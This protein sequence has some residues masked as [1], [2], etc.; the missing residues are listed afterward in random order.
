MIEL[1][2]CH[3]NAK[4][5]YKTRRSGLNKIFAGLLVL[6]V[7]AAGPLFAANTSIFY[8]GKVISIDQP[9]VPINYIFGIKLYPENLTVRSDEPIKYF[10][11]TL[12][13]ESNTTNNVDI[14]I[15]YV[16]Q[17]KGW[18]AQLIEDENNDG[19]HQDSEDKMLSPKQILA[20]GAEL[21]F[22]LRLA[23]PVDSRSG[24]AG[25]AIIKAS[26]AVK[27]GDSYVGYNGVTYGGPD[28][29]QT[30]DTVIVK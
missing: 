1:C 25:S 19:V 23:R 17:A 9:E 12:K 15:V 28:E 27:G 7:A 13:N 8:Q 5:V 3:H 4:I 10:P 16:S 22:F 14:D 30:T 11:H 26:C 21:K 20:E 29:V 2:I 18:S 6:F 24:D